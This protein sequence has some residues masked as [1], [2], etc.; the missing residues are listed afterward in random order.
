M[1]IAQRLE[2]A[3]KG[4]GG[5]K[6]KSGPR[7]APRNG[8]NVPNR[9]VSVVMKL[10]KAPPGAKGGGG[11][12][13]YHPAAKAVCAVTNPFCDEAV[14]ARYADAAAT[15]SLPYTLKASTSVATGSGGGGV[16]ILKATPQGIYQLSQVGGSTTDNPQLNALWVL[17]IGMPGEMDEARLTSWGVKGSTILPMTEQSGVIKVISLTD[18]PNVSSF[19]SI[20][21][22]TYGTIESYGATSGT[23]A[24]WIAKPSQQVQARRFLPPCTLPTTDTPDVEMSGWQTLAVA[25]SGA[26]G[27]KTVLYLEVTAHYEFTLGASTTLVPFAQPPPPPAPKVVQAAQQV[28]TLSP[29]THWNKTNESVDDWFKVA[30]SAAIRGLSSAASSYLSGGGWGGISEGLGLL[31]L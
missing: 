8:P 16:T 30:T 22:Y 13:K 24:H 15:R 19:F 23:T 11:S 12:S 21:A 27:G 31:M 14:G 2:M 10:P 17:L 3:K 29:Q 7:P 25:V 20:G 18:P 28:T 5:K 9:K 6:G 4:K 26:P 1:R